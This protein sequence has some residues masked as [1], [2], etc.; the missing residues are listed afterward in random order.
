MS[1]P[2]SQV[3]YPANLGFLLKLWGAMNSRT[4]VNQFGYLSAVALTE[5]KKNGPDVRA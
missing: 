1:S 5:L 2:S 3:D 4:D